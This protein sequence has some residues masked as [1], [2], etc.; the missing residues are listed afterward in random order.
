VL[1][2]VLTVASYFGQSDCTTL[3]GLRSTVWVRNSVFPANQPFST[4]AAE[5]THPTATP[6]ARVAAPTPEPRLRLVSSNPPDQ[7]HPT[8]P[9]RRT[10]SRIRPSSVTDGFAYPTRPG[11]RCGYV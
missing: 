4:R 1:P 5:F 11:R 8:R 3:W 10:D 6:S 7:L 2:D 9:T